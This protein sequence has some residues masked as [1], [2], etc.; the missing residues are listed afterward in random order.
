[1]KGS[2]ELVKGFLESRKTLFSNLRRNSGFRVTRRYADLMDLFIRSLF[3]EAGFTDTIR[4]PGEG[5]VAVVAL[6]S[7]GRR[8]FCFGSDVDLL[9]LHQG[10]LSPEMRR[11]IPRALYPLWDA[12]LEVGHT[13]LTVQECMRVARHDFRML[14]SIL[15]SR[16]LLGSRSFHRLF[17]TAFWS[18]LDREKAD[19]LGPFL[20]Y[21]QD[22]KE[23]HGR[24][25]HFIEPDI[26][27]GL[28]GLRDIHFMA[29]MAKIYF[30]CSLFSQIR[31]FALF[32]HFDIDTL[33]HSGSLLLKIRNHLHVL[34]GR[35]Q[36]R[37]LL[38]TQQ[39]L[40]RSLGYRDSPRTAA[41][42]KFMRELYLHL[43]RIRYGHE[44]FLAKALD[45]ISPQ[46]L[47]MIRNKVSSEFQVIKGN[48]VLKEG[49]I[50]EKDP[51]VILR[52]LK[53]ANEND[54]FIGSGL[55][56][57]AKKVIASEAKTLSRSSQARS[58]FLEIFLNPANPKIIRLSLEMGLTT[59]FIPE[60]KKIRNLVQA[61][62][63]HVETVDLH[64]LKALEVLM[65]ISKGAYDE[66]WPLFG[67][68]FRELANPERLFLAALLHD[69]GK[70]Y[71]GDHS[72]KGA[73][74]VPRIL[75]KFGVEA[76]AAEATAFLVLHHL[77]LVNVSQRR[78]LNEEKTSIQ[79]A[80]IVREK[81]TL[82]ALFL[83]TVADSFA[84][85]PI[86]RSDWKIMLL[87]ELF[88]KTRHILERGLF[89]SPDAAEKIEEGRKRLLKRM[90]SEFPERD[91]L[92]LMDEAPFRYFL[93]TGLGDMTEHFRL[94]LG[95]GEARFRWTLQKLADAPVTRILLCTY[96]RPG[97]F[98]KMAGV[99]SLNNIGVLSA[100]IFALKNGLVLDIYEVTNPRDPYREQER[101][102]KVL[103]EILLAV[104]DELPLDELINRKG[105]SVSVKE[106]Y[107]RPAAKKIRVDNEVSDFF[108]VIEIGSETRVGLL[109]ELAKEIF[110]RGLDIRFA[111]FNSD[112]E[113]MTGVFYVKDAT[114]QKV[115]DEE[116]IREIKRGLLAV[117]G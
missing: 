89:A 85:G 101:W 35:K 97:L 92:R 53:E 84:T 28:G 93:N 63:Y 105:R 90:V 111:K 22:R 4:G 59:L 103:K 78:D 73:E 3:I 102:D 71:E 96:D 20:F 87:I 82:E 109:Y 95:M 100:Q 86:A 5:A 55:I 91:V 83:L 34:S 12:K 15:D 58:L 74:I 48:V 64:S 29:W 36:D 42:E 25:G 10:R 77:L 70:G 104:E 75:K 31:R 45:I 23:K 32:S 24:E 14:T 99:F 33:S 66:R 67:E 98:S 81:E 11:V 113:K 57:E 9:I 65:G 43:N 112:E 13:V 116:Q 18:K 50:S 110:S 61:G 19:I 47:E 16:F 60:F 72:K 8:E 30:H 115:Y 49:T 68:V 37:I 79:V 76:E 2:A 1:M 6:G 17:E 26:K 40:A 94:A 21:E 106:R 80:Q 88:L 107:W 46:P 56:W 114:G 108:S 51:L 38:S 69:I 39:E 52:A 7:Y 117:M 44:E 27:E 54:L 62:S 41:A